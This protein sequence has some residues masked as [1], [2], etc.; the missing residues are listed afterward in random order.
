MRA[1][2]QNI[3]RKPVARMANRF[4]SRPDKQKIHEALTQLHQKIISEPGKRGPLM[5]F[6]CDQQKFIV[7][8]DQHKG[9]R[10]GADDFASAEYNYIEALNY[11]YQQGY[12]F[13]SLGDTEELWENNL[14][15]VKKAYPLLF[16]QEKLF[17]KQNRFTKIFGN[18]DL[19]WDN[20]PL[21]GFELEK[22]YGQKIKVYEGALLTTELHNQPVQIFLTHGHQGDKVSDGNW[23]SKWFVS[24]IW[25]PMQAY[26][27]IVPDTPAYYDHLKTEHNKLMYEWV[28]QQKNMLLITGHTHQPVFESLT[29]IERLFRKLGQ[30]NEATDQPEIEKIKGEIRFRKMEGQSIPDFTAYQ[31]T[32]FNSGCC[33]FG[34]GDITGIEIEEG[35]IRLIKW[36]YDNKSKPNRHLLEEIKIEK[37]FVFNQP[38]PTYTQT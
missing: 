15:A 16:E 36:E 11:Y 34:D 28:A 38:P 12:H 35:C 2:L 29:H 23:F 10:N 18:H 14:A 20:D 37:L 25:A 6:V 26:L 3:L 31:P 19:Y 13:I 32:Y 33:C 7:L 21:A 22:I 27:A 4:S 30:L 17:L 8:S 5:Q 9:A 24:T 1:F